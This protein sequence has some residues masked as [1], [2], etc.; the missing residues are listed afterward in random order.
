VTVAP[1]RAMAVYEDP[2]LL[3]PDE[4]LHP[5]NPPIEPCP[6]RGLVQLLFQGSV[7]FRLACWAHERFGQWVAFAQ[8]VV[9]EQVCCIDLARLVSLAGGRFL[10]ALLEQAL[11]VSFCW[12]QSVGGPSA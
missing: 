9:Q 4:V 11:E 8:R 12:A 2:S 1:T 10:D 3:E 6:V 7:V 5:L